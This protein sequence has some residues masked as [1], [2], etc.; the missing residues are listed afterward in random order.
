MKEPTDSVPGN[1][2]HNYI[3]QLIFPHLLWM[4]WNVLLCYSVWFFR[5]EFLLLFFQRLAGQYEG[6]SQFNFHN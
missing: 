6:I 1:S 3:L 2:I 5:G 4:F